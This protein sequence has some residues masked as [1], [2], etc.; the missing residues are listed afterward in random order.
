MRRKILITAALIVSGIVV[1][2]VLYSP[3]A[4]AGFPLT[5]KWRQTRV[6]QQYAKKNRD[7]FVSGVSEPIDTETFFSERLGTCV[8]AQTF[9][10][11]NY[12]VV[13]LT[14]TYSDGD[15]LFI[16][17]PQGLYV[18][19]FSSRRRRWLEEGTRPDRPCEK[20]FKETLNE[21]Q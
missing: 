6:C 21:I 4:H 15:W 17:S 10:P 2:L 9:A 16:C 12:S 1:G 5:H 20:L 18:T 8:Q 3:T 13:D 11:N 14:R 19:Q 7:I